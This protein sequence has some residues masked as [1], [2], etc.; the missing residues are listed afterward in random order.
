MV[1]RSRVIEWETGFK[2]Q[3]EKDD[4]Y[5]FLVV[6]SAKEKRKAY[7]LRKRLSR[8]SRICCICTRRAQGRK[9]RVRGR[10]LA[11][12]IRGVAFDPGLQPCT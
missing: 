7:G 8:G 1:G 6:L 3:E 12:I 5:D 10:D 2:T 11:F 9:R 4:A